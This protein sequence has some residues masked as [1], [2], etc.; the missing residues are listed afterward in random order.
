M[1]VIEVAF[2]KIISSCSAIIT[3][4]SVYSMIRNNKKTIFTFLGYL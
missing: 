2:K 4:I 3:K 1:N